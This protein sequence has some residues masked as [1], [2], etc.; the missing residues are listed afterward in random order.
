[1]ANQV[2]WCDIPVRDLERAIRF[3]SAVLGLDVKRHDFS[4]VTVGILP[5]DEG[6][7]GGCLLTN[8]EEQPGK[9]GVMIYLNASGRLD[10]AVAAVPVNGGSV[11][12]PKHAIGPFGFRAIVIDSEGNRVALHSE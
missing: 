10:E 5:H 6:E 1:M 11:I 7:V 9:D 8:Q 12:K 2:V 3:Y 4:G